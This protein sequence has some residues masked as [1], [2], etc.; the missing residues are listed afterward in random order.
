M[1]YSTIIMINIEYRLQLYSFRK[2]LGNLWKDAIYHPSRNKSITHEETSRDDK[3]LFDLDYFY[4][5]DF[6]E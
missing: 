2:G 3:K 6:S 1:E 5:V 4:P